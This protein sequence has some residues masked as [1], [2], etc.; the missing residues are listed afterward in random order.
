VK[1]EKKDD[2]TTRGRGDAARKDA[3]IAGLGAFPKGCVCAHAVAKG[4][5]GGNAVRGIALIRWGEQT[6]SLIS[7]SINS[8]EL[9]VVDTNVP[10]FADVAD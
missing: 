8:F 4:D 7:I 10:T 6:Y 9:A 5:G 1:R 2:A 3:T